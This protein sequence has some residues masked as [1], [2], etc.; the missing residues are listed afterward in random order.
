MIENE[1]KSVVAENCEEYNP[2]LKISAM[3]VGK[4]CN[5]CGNCVNFKGEKCVKGL[6]ED[7]KDIIRIN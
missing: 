7:I 1:M 2:K 4:S 5:S 3:S 6:Y